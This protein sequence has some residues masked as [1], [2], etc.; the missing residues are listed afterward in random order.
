VQ[1][2]IKRDSSEFSDRHNARPI[3]FAENSHCAIGKV[4]I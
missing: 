2:G 3:A 4:K 1:P